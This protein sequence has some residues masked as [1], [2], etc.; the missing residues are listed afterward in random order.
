MKIKVNCKVCKKSFFTTP[1]RIKNNRGKYCSRKC[2]FKSLERKISR[3][4]GNCKKTLS[5]VR[6]KANQTNNNFCSEKCLSMGRSKIASTHLVKWINKNKGFEKQKFGLNGKAISLDGYYIYNG[7]K[8]HRL[9]MEKHIGRKLKS[10]E[11]VHHINGNKFDNRIE[12]LQIVSRAEHNK[13]HFKKN[14][15]K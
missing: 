9:L 14:K 7:I 2:Q 15:K 1:D 4:C 8:V 11:I 12:N 13:I 5:I 6:S 3:K 10:S